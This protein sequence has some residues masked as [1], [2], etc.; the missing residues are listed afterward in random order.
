MSPSKIRD[1]CVGPTRTVAPVVGLILSRE[2]GKLPSS[3]VSPYKMP[4]PGSYVIPVSVL[5][6]PVLRGL[7]AAPVVM[8][9][10]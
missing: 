3:A 8:L 1:K 7:V 6:V 5:L 9:T 2:F 4:D 10:S